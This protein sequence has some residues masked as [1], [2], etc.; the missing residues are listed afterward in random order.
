MA[1]L[2]LWH[3]HNYTRLVSLYYSHW[4]TFLFCHRLT[5]CHWLRFWLRWADYKALL[6][7]LVVTIGK[8]KL[9]VAH[10]R[11]DGILEDNPRLL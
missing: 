3:L 5:L 8:V 2:F 9:R 4:I 6:Y 10:W 7:D 11:Q 1:A